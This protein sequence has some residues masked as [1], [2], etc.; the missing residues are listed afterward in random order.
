MEVTSLAKISGF[1][2]YG[3]FEFIDVLVKVLLQTISTSLGFS[4]GR[5]CKRRHGK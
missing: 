5:Y 2:K 4:Y 3:I 1:N